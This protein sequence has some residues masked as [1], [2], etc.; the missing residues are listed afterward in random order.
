MNN[1]AQFDARLAGLQGLVGK[2]AEQQLR[3]V[4]DT[5]AFKQEITG[6]T[7]AIARRQETFEG[8]VQRVVLSIAKKQEN[9]EDEMHRVVLEMRRIAEVQREGDER[10]NMLITIVDSLVR[11]EKQ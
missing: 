2:I 6:I 9:F 7:L 5:G 10:L 1:Q 4:E 11:R 3:F 8:E